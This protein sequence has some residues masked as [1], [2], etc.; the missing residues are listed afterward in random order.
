M[1]DEK[2]ATD[3]KSVVID[4]LNGVYY[5]S[6]NVTDDTAIDSAFVNSLSN[7]VLSDSRVRTIQVTAGD[8]QYIY[9]CIPTRLGTPTFAVGG[10][11]GGFNLVKTFDFTNPSNH[12]ESYNVYRSSHDNLGQTE[13]VI[14]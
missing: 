8:K 5:G 10:F 1:K 3:K 12:T 6:S 9:Y 13:V 14:K 4:F 11:A 7:K 2:D